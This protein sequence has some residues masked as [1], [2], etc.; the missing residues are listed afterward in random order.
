MIMHRSLAL[1]A[2]I[3]AGRVIMEIYDSG[4]F[5]VQ[6]KSDESPLTKADLAAH[7]AIKE[8]LGASDIPILSEEGRHVEYSERCNWKTLW[9]IDPIDGTKEFIKRNGEFTVN[10]ALVEEGIPTLGV[11]LVPALGQLFIGDVQNGA[12]WVEHG[13]LNWSP[14][15]WLE[16]SISI[17]MERGNR[18]FTVVA[19]RSHMSEETESYIKELQGIHGEIELISKGSSLKLCMVAAGIADCYPRFAPT[20]EW[21]TAAG[22]AVCLAAHCEVLDWNTQKPLM[23]NRE[24]LLNPWFLVRKAQA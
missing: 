19:S 21:D 16:S 12:R 13:D 1:E 20:M 14:S 5:E 6:L 10:I 22:Q 8:C 23:Y 9:I 24:D 4:E 11:V 2:A 15:Q 18:P 17:P 3:A 7:H